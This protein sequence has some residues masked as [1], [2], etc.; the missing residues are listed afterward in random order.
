MSN[1][2]IGGYD[3]LDENSKAGRSDCNG[4][5]LNSVT[6]RYTLSQNPETCRLIYEGI[7]PSYFGNGP[8]VE[9]CGTVT[10]D[11]LPTVAEFVREKEGD[12]VNPMQ[13]AQATTG[14]PMPSYQFMGAL[15]PQY[16]DNSQPTFHAANIISGGGNVVPYGYGQPM[17]MPTPVPMQPFGMYPN[18]P[19]VNKNGEIN[20]A[21]QE[22]EEYQ[23]TKGF[24]APIPLDTDFPEPGPLS[25]FHK[26]FDPHQRLLQSDE[27]FYDATLNG[28]IG[29][30]EWVHQQQ[31]AQYAGVWGYVPG[32]V[33]DRRE[34]MM[35]PGI[36]EDHHCSTP[37]TEPVLNHQ[38]VPQVRS[39]PRQL[40]NTILAP[41]QLPIA[42]M[43]ANNPYMQGVTQIGGQPMYQQP[44]AVP[45]PYMQA[46]YNYAIANGFQSVQ[47]MDNND[48]FVLKKISRCVN[49]DMTPEEF[50]EH[51]E[52]CWCKRF[53]DIYDAEK[54]MKEDVEKLAQKEKAYHPSARLIKNGKILTEVK[55][56]DPADVREVDWRM[57]RARTINLPEQVAKARI[58]QTEFERRKDAA[59]TYLYEHAPER[60]YDHDSVGFMCHGIVESYFYDLAFEDWKWWN[61]PK[62]YQVQHGIN[63]TEFMRNILERGRGFGTPAAH[64]RLAAENEM[65]YIGKD[66][67]NDEMDARGYLRGSY[68]KGPDGKPLDDMVMPLYGYI[69]IADPKDPTRSIPFP[70]RYLKDLHEGYLR[71]AAA[72]GSKAK[73]PFHVMDYQEF[74]TACGVRVMEDE[75][76]LADYGTFEPARKYIDIAERGVRMKKGT[77]EDLN[78]PPHADQQDEDQADFDDPTADIPMDE[79][80][81]QVQEDDDS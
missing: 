21:K 67:V 64:S 66:L 55:G 24:R 12:Y 60:K 78:R 50:E 32:Q 10:V 47:E 74:E 26:G 41:N 16:H 75:D 2:V 76:W 73:K 59:F 46:R 23:R 8:T 77:Y 15:A 45:T 33:I 70:R 7:I 56:D 71:F 29:I 1:C 49:H 80:L 13:L 6:A 27:E 9:D 62:R 58:A 11:Q 20:Y 3:M 48:F 44:A 54:K 36:N 51:F 39:T 43:V 22:W 65:F 69:T 42:N 37:S 38:G 17:P 18:N 35:F 25:G 31:L 57:Q 5:N 68:G 19:P 53:T 28:R 81:R 30:S 14:Q 52:R 72:S 79:L 34:N 40:G 63:Q 4:I 61:S